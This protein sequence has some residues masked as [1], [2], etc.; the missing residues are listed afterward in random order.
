MTASTDDVPGR[1]FMSYRRQDTAY[2]ASWL[3]DR[4]A[5]HFGRD[6]VFKD[7]DSIELGDDFID[8]ITTAV[9]SCDVLL[10]LIGDRWLTTTDS[11]GQRRLD[12][13]HDFVRLEI[14]A[15]LARNVRIIPILVEGAL[16]PR[17]NELPASLAKLARRQA[18]EL[19]PNRFDVDTRRLLRVLDRTIAEAQKLARQE[20]E[21]STRYRQQV[22]QLQGRIHERAAAQDWDAVVAASDELAALD[23]AA[24]DPDGLVSAARGQIARR[25][26]A[27]PTP[28]G[29]QQPANDQLTELDESPREAA[30]A[31]ELTPA[32]QSGARPVPIPATSP[33]GVDHGRPSRAGNDHPPPVTDVP[34]PR[35][36]EEPRSATGLRL[37][38]HAISRRLVVVAAVVGVAVVGLAIAII[39]ANGTNSTNR[40]NITNCVNGAPVPTSGCVSGR[41]SSR[42]WAYTTGGQVYS[43]PAVADGTVYIGSYDGNVYALDAATGHIRWTYT[44]SGTVDSSPAVADRTV[45][46]GSDDGNVYALDAATGH[47][48]WTY[49]T[50]GLA[51]AAKPVVAGGTVY[52][53]SDD[54][55]VYALD[56]ATGHVRWT[57]TTGD[58]VFSS[59]AVAGRTVY[60]GS[61]DHKVYALDAAT[62]HVRWT[63]TTGSQVHSSPAVAGGAIYIGSE[64]YTVYDLKAA[65]S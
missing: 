64:D 44:T 11:D 59:P 33:D 37:A 51:I 34:G 38:G 60:I 29:A 21:R 22:E 63:Y 6:Q 8:V 49:A 53:G 31:Q 16:M 4:L 1:I 30:G 24:A 45:Y 56:A 15:A 3:Y 58:Q 32:G 17:A 55:K 19:S 42:N 46:V 26:Q 47:V 25:Q 12:D 28:I 39:I 18:L 9:G 7:V 14:E 20:V 43:S 27:E 62:G 54:H 61:D 41:P 48:R 52:I 13:P 57:Y 2:P 5:S 36:K 10:A 40:T 65:G 23:P 50:G 35:P